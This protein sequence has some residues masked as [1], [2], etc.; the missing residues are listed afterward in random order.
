MVNRP[1]NNLLV[2]SVSAV[3]LIPIV[4][5]IILSSLLL[6]YSS[7]VLIAVLMGVEWRGLV[8]RLQSKLTWSLVALV[9]ISSFVFALCWLR[10]QAVGQSLLIWL[11]VTTW[12][13]DIGAFAFGK[14]I[15]GPKLVPK[16]SPSKT[17]A[18]LVGA[19]VF[20]LVTGLVF[21]KVF[22]FCISSNFIYITILLGVISQAGDLL[23]SWI[24]RQAGVK[25]SGKMIPGHGGI[26]DRVDGLVAGSVA[27]LLLLVFFKNFIL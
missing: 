20:S 4:L 25:D 15:G 6:F 18:G 17:W 5:Y 23:E 26:L 16:I 10:H 12:M 7:I 1:Q 3:L 14:T 13:S 22:N 11:C 19:I 9:Y 21:N 27:L 24:K 8:T 2:R